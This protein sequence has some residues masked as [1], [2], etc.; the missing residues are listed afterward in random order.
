MPSEKRTKSAA[1]KAQKTVQRGL[2]TYQM[3]QS[4]VE[5]EIKDYTAETKR[6]NRDNNLV[7]II[8]EEHPHA[9]YRINEGRN[10]HSISDAL[11]DNRPKRMVSSHSSI[12]H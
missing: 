5:K 6:L 12:R 3:R 9:I 10:Y 11:R 4:W 2:T 7:Y 1:V 8:K